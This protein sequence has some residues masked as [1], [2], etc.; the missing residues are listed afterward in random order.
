MRTVSPAFASPFS[1]W[2]W[3]FFERR[4][5]LP[6]IGWMKRR[7]TFTTTVLEFLSLTTTPC[8][9]RLGISSSSSAGLPALFVHHGHNPRD[10]LADFA[11]TARLLKLA[12]GALK[13]EVELL[14]LQLRQLVATLV[15]GAAADVFDGILRLRHC[16]SYPCARATNFVATESFA[17]PSRMDSFA[18]SRSTPSISKRIRPGFTFATQ[19]SGAPLPEPMRT[20]AGFFDTGTS[21]N[22]RIHTR[23]ARFMWRVMARRAASISRAV[24][25][26]GSNVLRPYSPKFSVVPPLAGP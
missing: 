17:A 25:R 7:S 1:S 8:S 4:T 2:A 16:R 19:N 3:Y 21:G 13:T 6:S 20:S 9:T 24:M 18:V 11:H 23:P 5:V 22:T 10:L 26:S 12:V 15:G 14:L